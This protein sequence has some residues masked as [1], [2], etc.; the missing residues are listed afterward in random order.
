MSVPMIEIQAIAVVTAVACALPGVFLVL[1][2]MAMMSDAI[3]HSILFG[4]VIAFFL[5]KTLHSPALIIGA[6]LTGVLT[7]TLVQL[8][9]KTRLVN[10][11]AAIGLVFPLLFSI[12]VIL[13]SRYAGNIHLDTD[14][15]LLGELAFAPFDRM[16]I[17][18][19][20]LG[21]KSIWVMSTILLLNLLFIILFY[22]EL[23]LSTFDAGLAMTL[24]FAPVTLHYITM[25][26]VSLTA[27]GAF[28]AVGS[29]LVVALMIVPAGTAY[30]L[31][32]RLAVMLVLSAL[33]AA[34]SAIAGYWIAHWLDASIAG[35][36]AT[37]CGILFGLTFSFS[38]QRGLVS[39]YNRRRRQKYEFARQML[40][41]HLY[42]H[43]GLEEEDAEAQI[44]HLQDH[45]RWPSGFAQ[46]VIQAAEKRNWLRV[47]GTR[48]HLQEKG[49]EEAK[50]AMVR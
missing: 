20:D 35:S 4:I 29:I 46:Q 19:M 17:G 37:V 39:I 50:K 49:V 28:E 18:G 27:V 45:F 10:E 41:V 6:A 3:S 25:T 48:L 1:R 43:S 42:Q 16:V 31:T 24:G 44:S 15:V 14:A 38:P 22:K 11:D 13:I 32:D 26:L 47:E 8:L 21:P 12:G 5:V 33:V 2:K 34:I 30:L 36:I 7:V 40:A 9:S 23:K